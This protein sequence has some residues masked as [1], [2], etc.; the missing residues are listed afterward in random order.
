MKIAFIHLEPGPVGFYRAWQWGRALKERGHDVWMRPH[1]PDQFSLDEIDGILM[2]QDV[3]VCGRTHNATTWAALLA[4]RH[5]YHFK[6][7]VDT[8]DD[9]DSIPEYN[10]AFADYH[11]GAGV[12][13]VIRAEYRDADAV[14]VS[15]LPL[16]DSVKRYNDSIYHAPNVID[17][18]DWKDVRTREKEDRHKGD[19]RIYWGG[20][21]GHFDDLETVR[22]PLLRICKEYPQVKLVFSN[23]VPAWA[24][25]RLPHTRV[26]LVP[27]VDIDKYRRLLTWICA[28]I[29]IA[30]LVKNEFNRGK[31]N[32]KYL[33]YSMAGICG[34]YQDLEPYNGSVKDNIT[35][36]LADSPME[37]YEAIRNLI[38]SPKT[39][40][41]LALSANHHVMRS[42]SLSG[43]VEGY[44]SFLAGLIEKKEAACA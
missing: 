30:P 5:L 13:R 3:V 24:V 38:E 22:V 34:I 2:D 43:A 10:Q 36:I 25:E 20:G 17:P 19:L 23:F 18:A 44:E 21:G 6:L 11:D 35:G 29:G 39:R 9:V 26:F 37:W 32:L 1:L 41:A 4:A 28:D 31:S 40:R 14:T 8:D 33:D 15:T 7:V 42:Y 12:K 16:R 27:M